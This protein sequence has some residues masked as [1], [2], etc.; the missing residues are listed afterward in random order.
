MLSV[1]EQQ[2]S[3]KYSVELDH[4]YTNKSSDSKL[5]DSL[6]LTNFASSSD[7]QY[8]HPSSPSTVS[9]ISSPSNEV[10][11]VKPPTK[12]VSDNFLK[13][14]YFSFYNILF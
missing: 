10:E 6:P 9:T 12:T 14:S 3:I 11:K 5:K 8:T 4:C 1:E 2:K 7:V 13:C